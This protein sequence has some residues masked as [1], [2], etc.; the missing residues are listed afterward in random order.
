MHEIIKVNT[1]TKE[2]KWAVQ[3]INTYTQLAAIKA[4]GIEREIAVYGDPFNLGILVRGVID[5]LEYL[6]QSH[7]LTLLDNKTRKG[8]NLPGPEQKKGTALQLMLYK[9]LLDNMILGITKTGLLFKHFKLNW[10]AVLT[11]GPVDYIKQCGL[12]S[13]LIDNDSDS[14]TTKPNF[15]DV[16]YC[17]SRLITGLDL[18]LVSTLMVQYEHQDSKEVLGVDTVDYNEQWMKETVER[19]IEFW[20]GQRSAHGVDIEEAWKCTSCQFKD[21]C[22]LKLQRELESSPAAKVSSH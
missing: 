9:C 6:P 7:E 15:S 11:E 13:V 2:D 21:I 14:T 4:G 10:N 5:Q 20:K 19:S 17:V 16:A 3:L 12:S 22:V 18:P 1:I 8:K